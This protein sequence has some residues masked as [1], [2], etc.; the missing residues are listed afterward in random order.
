MTSSRYFDKTHLINNLAILTTLAKHLADS[1]LS[2][3]L[4][5]ET[6]VSG[7]A[8]TATQSFFTFSHIISGLGGFAILP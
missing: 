1:V 3:N 5:Y 7:W 8:G 6:R 2:K 4:R